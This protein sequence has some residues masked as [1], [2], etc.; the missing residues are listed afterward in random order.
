MPFLTAFPYIGTPH[1]GYAHTHHDFG[2]A[3]RVALATSNGPGLVPGLF[4][5]Q[6][7]R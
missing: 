7:G 2:P 6:A 5:F 1:Q 4:G 3:S